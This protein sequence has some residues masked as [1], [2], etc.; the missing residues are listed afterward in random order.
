MAW[1]SGAGE[2]VAELEWFGIG[3]SGA[4]YCQGI[5]SNN[6]LVSLNAV[7]ANNYDIAVIDTPLA[8]PSYPVSYAGAGRCQIVLAMALPLVLQ[9]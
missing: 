7:Q 8:D 4:P 9:E 3:A 6:H 1:G 2:E 5:P